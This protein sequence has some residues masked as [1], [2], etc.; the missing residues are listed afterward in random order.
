MIIP[1]S[2]VVPSDKTWVLSAARSIIVTSAAL[3]RPLSTDGCGL[4]QLFFTTHLAYT[5]SLS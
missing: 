1:T 4:P 2:L 5:G 3:S